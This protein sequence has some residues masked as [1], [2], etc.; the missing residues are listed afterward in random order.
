MK[1]VERYFIMPGQ[2][3]AYKIGML[4]I[5]Q[6]R[7]KAKKQLEGKFKITDFHRVILEDGAVPLFILEEKVNL[8]ITQTLIKN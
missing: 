8:W 3:T 2:A 7:A 1:G 6:L 4:K 5:L